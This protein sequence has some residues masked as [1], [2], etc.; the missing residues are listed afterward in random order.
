MRPHRPQP[1]RLPRPWDTPG[2]NT[3]VGCHFLGL[4][5]KGFPSGSAMKNLPA[6]QENQIQ[7]LGQKD[8]LEKEMVTNSSILVWEIPWTEEPSGVQSP[9]GRKRVRHNLATKQQLIIKEQIG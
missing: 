4:I 5:I 3:G 2:K 1:T 8:P 7:S 6:M 9:W